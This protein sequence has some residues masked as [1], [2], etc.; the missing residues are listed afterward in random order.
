V[1]NAVCQVASGELFASPSPSSSTK[2]KGVC[3]QAR[4]R[5]L[6]RG[7]RV[8]RSS[9]SRSCVLTAENF[10]LSVMTKCPG[11]HGHEQMPA[12]IRFSLAYRAREQHQAGTWG[13]FPQVH[14]PCSAL[15][16]CY[17]HAA[18]GNWGHKDPT[19][20]ACQAQRSQPDEQLMLVCVW[21]PPLPPPIRPFPLRTWKLPARTMA[22][23]VPMPRESP[24]Y[25][26]QT[27]T[28]CSQDTDQG[29]RWRKICK[30]LW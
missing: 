1:V 28:V 17:L 10:R 14:L 8:R 29:Q 21:T 9:Q 18:V 16:G 6:E 27:V 20:E 13:D 12:C 26:K 25:G 2:N 5:L 4:R 19:R 22:R 15:A 7:T 30:S 11:L 24:T 23:D 3:M